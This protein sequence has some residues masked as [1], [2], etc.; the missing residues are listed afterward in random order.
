MTKPKVMVVDDDEGI[1]TQLRYALQDEY[2]VTLA[3][4]RQ[5]ALSLLQEVQPAVVS[6]DLGLPPEPDGAEEGLKTLDEILRAAPLT[7]VIVVTGNSDR[8]NALRAVELGAFDYHLKP[9]NLADYKVVVRR[10][11]FLGDLSRESEAAARVDE[12][13]VRFEEIIGKTTRMREIYSVVQR[14]A[15]TDATVLIEGESGTG[16]ELIARAIHRRS[17]RRDGPFVA[18]N[19]GAIPETL[20]E[21]ELFGHER[22]AFTGAHVQ[23][24]G[25]FEMA[26]RGTLFLD[27]IGEL[28]LTLQ[29]KILRF[30]QERTVERI[31]GR[32]P[33]AVE[34]R[35]IAATNR[36]LKAHLERGLFREDLYYRLS[37]VRVDVPPLRERAEDVVILA[38]AFLGR[39]AKEQRRS[40]RFGPRALQALLAHAWPGNVR[41]LENRVSRAVIMTKGRVIE[42]ADLDLVAADGG[43]DQGSLR[44]TRQRVERQALVDVLSRHRGNV[45]QAARELK[46][47]RPTL[48]GLLDKHEINAKDFR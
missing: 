9:I 14:V 45:S 40:V 38:N 16:K 41:E 2:V 25:K 10:A 15:K 39:A 46:I 31:G 23:R 30:L 6:L 37:V 29:V 4:N 5:Q 26:E 32:Q 3:E 36:D 47:S 28:P 12:Q 18:I 8:G 1:R 48:H 21:S 17:I 44:E 33:I 11:A 13:G 43:P 34:V 19:C 27:E 22:G 35:I 24:K 20:L 7:K 42:P